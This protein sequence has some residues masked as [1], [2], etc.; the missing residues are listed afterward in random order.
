MQPDYVFL[1]WLVHLQKE[2]ER[3]SYNYFHFDA[4]ESSTNGKYG[5]LLNFF[6]FILRNKWKFQLKERSARTTLKKKKKMVRLNYYVLKQP[7]WKLFVAMVND[8]APSKKKMTRPQ[9]DD[10][11]T[12]IQGLGKLL[13]CIHS[14]QMS[15][16]INPA[17]KP[18]QTPANFKRSWVN[19][20]T[21]R[22]KKI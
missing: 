14:C 7:F 22:E 13:D 19:F 8:A 10:T 6:A 11:D 3:E 15:T 21:S 1:I 20:S 2:P 18:W 9:A 12:E 17:I 5:T 4:R 16:R